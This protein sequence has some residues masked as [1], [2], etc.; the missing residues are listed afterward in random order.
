[1]LLIT[2]ARLACFIV[3]TFKP[4]E[5]S[6]WFDSPGWPGEPNNMEVF[7]PC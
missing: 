3:K 1:M 5:P 7:Q 2:I 6:Y 4:S